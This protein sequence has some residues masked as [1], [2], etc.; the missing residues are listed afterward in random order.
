MPL[1]NST[2]P[3]DW[4]TSL[5][6]DDSV[7]GGGGNLRRTHRALHLPLA[8]DLWRWGQRRLAGHPTVSENCFLS[9]DRVG[10]SLNGNR[11]VPT[12]GDLT[13]VV[14]AILPVPEQ[15]RRRDTPRGYVRLWDGTGPSRSDP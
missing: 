1:H 12:A 4:S 8:N 9:I 5:S 2:S 14:T 3:D 6:R 10:D 13:A 11:E 7:E 15:F